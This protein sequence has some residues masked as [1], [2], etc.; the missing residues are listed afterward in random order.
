[1][2]GV[3]FNPS[4]TG[5]STGATLNTNNNSK[6]SNIYNNPS[7]PATSP[8]PAAQPTPK[9]TDSDRSIQIGAMAETLKKNPE[10]K[11]AV[12]AKLISAR[13]GYLAT[14]TRTNNIPD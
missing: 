1:M 10:N 13:F 14:S 8:T 3:Q 4:T 9:R 5:G 7:T 12:M 2:S 6:I 11:E